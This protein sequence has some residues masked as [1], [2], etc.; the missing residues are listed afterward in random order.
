VFIRHYRAKYHFEPYL[1]IWMATEILSF[2]V[3]SRMYAAL[4]KN[5]RKKIADRFAQPQSVFVSWLHALTAIRNVCA[6]HSRLWNRELSVK[7]ML[8]SAWNSGQIDNGRFYVV[9]LIIQTLLME[10]AP[11]SEWKIKL[12]AAIDSYPSADLQAMKFPLGW[13]SAQPWSQPSGPG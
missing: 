12:K 2:G 8:P 5:L 10:I 7:P 3:L 11:D 9:A 6:H 13:Y 1:P 4:R